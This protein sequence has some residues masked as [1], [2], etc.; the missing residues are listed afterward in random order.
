MECV[1][2]QFGAKVS[3]VIE[4]SYSTETELASSAVRHLVADSQKVTLPALLDLSAAFYYVD[5]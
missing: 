3:V 4:T 1:S 5:P 2:K